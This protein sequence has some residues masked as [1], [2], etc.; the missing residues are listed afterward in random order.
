MMRRSQRIR[1][2]RRLLIGVGVEGGGDRGAEAEVVVVVVVGSGVGGEGV[3]GEVS[4]N[5]MQTKREGRDVG[6]SSRMG[7]SEGMEFDSPKSNLN[8]S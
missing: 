8:L 4:R 1:L 3:V 5:S 6:P 7:L 2:G